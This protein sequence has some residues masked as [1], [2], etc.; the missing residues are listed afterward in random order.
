MVDKTEGEMLEEIFS[1]WYFQQAMIGELVILNGGKLLCA[2]SINTGCTSPSMY[3]HT[4]GSPIS[5]SRGSYEYSSGNNHYTVEV[6][7]LLLGVVVALELLYRPSNTVL[8]QTSSQFTSV[9]KSTS[10]FLTMYSY[11]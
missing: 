3:R 4:F 2:A 10:K 11:H 7:H 1:A 9:T 8:Y 5:A 6:D